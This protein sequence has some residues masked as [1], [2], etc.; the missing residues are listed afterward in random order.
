M[1]LQASIEEREMKFSLRSRP[2]SSACSAMDNFDFVQLAPLDFACGFIDRV[3]FCFVVSKKRELLLRK[4]FRKRNEI[5]SLILKRKGQLH[6]I[7]TKVKVLDIFS[8]R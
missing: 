5:V 2:M 4:K 6:L 3:T 8:K 7:S 1:S